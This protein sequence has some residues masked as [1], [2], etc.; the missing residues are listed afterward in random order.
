MA[1]SGTITGG[2][3]GGS[4][5]PWLTLAWTQVSQSVANN[6][7]TL[8]LTLRFNWSA[9][10]NYTFNKRTGSVQ[11]H[12]YTYSGSASGTS[13]S[14]VLRTQKVT[15][16]HNSNGAKSVTL[17]GNI[18]SLGLY[19]RVSGTNIGTMS[20][21]GT[22]TLNPITRAST[23]SAFSFDDH[24]KNDVA[25][26]INYTID[27]SSDNFRHQF[28]LRDGSTTVMKWD[29]IS[30]DGKS[31][32][33]LTASEVNSLL[34][35]MR[36][37]TTKSFTLRVATRSG[38]DGEWI[39]SAVSRNATATVHEDVKPS[40]GS[41]I[42]YQTG[43]PNSNDALQGFSKIQAS[44]TRSAGYGASMSSSSIQV[45]KSSGGGDSQ[46]I[47]SNNGTTPNPVSLY[48]VYEA[49]GTARDSRGRTTY[50]DWATITVISYR[51][52]TITDFSVVR[53]SEEPTTVN[54]S[55]ATN[56][57]VLGIGNHL[58]YTIQR[59]QGTGK[60]TNISSGATGTITTSWATGTATSTGNSAA[61]SYEFRLFVKDRMGGSTESIRSITTQ[62]VVLDIH[63][64]EGV[65]IGKIRE[66][67]VLDVDGAAHFK[68]ELHV[69]P[70][71]T[72]S[73][74]NISLYSSAEA[75]N[76]SG[77]R[78][79]SPKGINNASLGY[80]YGSNSEVFALINHRGILQVMGNGGDLQLRTSGANNY[81]TIDD[82]A[83][84]N[85]HTKVIDYGFSS[86]SGRYLKFYNGYMICWYE[87]TINTSSARNTTLVWNFPAEF[88]STTG[89]MTLASKTNY[90]GSFNYT[91]GSVGIG[92]ASKLSAK[93]VFSN[94]T[95]DND[96]ADQNMPIQVMAIGR[97]R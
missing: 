75:G 76:N 62:R 66:K 91:N 72:S 45:R 49:R 82:N 10:I 37:S 34:D 24:L 3:Y 97:W 86:G 87:M 36:S 40:V 65:G 94:A 21:S 14:R 6:T 81:V 95:H 47:N 33:P 85:E 11:G 19:W 79:K 93:A 41:V 51:A 12:S 88:A 83:S 64:N 16:A 58:T 74:E 90:T 7:T 5:G 44:F 89:L 54:I 18:T 23:L 13:G 39:G 61:Q 77:I 56:H 46:T 38:V 42:L 73:A 84:G 2:R 71:D 69:V 31:T 28:Q 78:F 92:G 63:K 80:I 20:V 57:T 32:L 8:D 53:D 29:N 96:L 55:R 27:R 4:S 70:I 48:G 15:I 22:A 30:S 68:G 35:G 1:S 9:N 25:N 60:W 26:Q 59:R 43:N 52:P 50:T 67:G 17:S